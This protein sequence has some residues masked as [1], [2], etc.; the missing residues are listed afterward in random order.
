MGSTKY[1]QLTHPTTGWDSDAFYDEGLFLGYVTTKCYPA[2]IPHF[3]TKKE[4][5]PISTA[6]DRASIACRKNYDR[7]AKYFFGLDQSS[8]PLLEDNEKNNYL[9]IGE[10]FGVQQGGDQWSTSDEQKDGY[11]AKRT[12]I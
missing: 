2:F 3:S 4:P 6:F 10:G 8:N 12:Y 5:L 11:L 7:A 1:G 9:P